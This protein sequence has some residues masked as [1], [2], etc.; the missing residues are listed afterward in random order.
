M[1][2]KCSIFIL[3]I[4]LAC[5]LT[6]CVSEKTREDIIACLE[7]E[8]VIEDDWEFEYMISNDASPIPDIYSY[9]YIYT[10]DDET[11]AVRIQNKNSDDEYLVFIAEDVEIEES[12]WTNADGETKTDRDVVN[13][14][15]IESYTLKYEQ[16]L[17]FKYMTI[18]DS[19]KY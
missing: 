10:E 17:W 15:T 18:T 16:F 12:E 11:Y 9:D 8:G 7:K 13:G 1:K 2:K 3:T 4:L 5:T 6:G 19:E 14:E